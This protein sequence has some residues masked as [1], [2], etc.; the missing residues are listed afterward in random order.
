MKIL[1]QTTLLAFLLFCTPITS[2][3]QETDLPKPEP[4]FDV[5]ASDIGTWDVEIHTSQGPGEATVSKGTETN[6]MLGGFW[7]LSDFQGKMMGLDFQGHG[8]YS[9]DA[10][11]KQYVGTWVDSLSPSKMDMVGKYDKTNKTMTYQGI[12]PGADGKPAKH[13]MTTNYHDDE[14]RLMTMHMQTGKDMI[15]VFEMKYTKADDTDH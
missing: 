13:V 6:R 8:I 11:K 7:L 12:A 10:E 1:K 4:E 5:F 3:A 15:K 2:I 9:Y 14:N